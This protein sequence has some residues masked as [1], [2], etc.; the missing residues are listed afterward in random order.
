MK[1]SAPYRAFIIRCWQ[2]QD[3]QLDSCVYRFSLE[4]P[5]TGERIGFTSAKELIQ[6]L[7]LALSQIYATAIADEKL[8]DEPIEENTPSQS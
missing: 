5:V 4:T 7:E 8:G 6:A 3:G 2:E 1:Q